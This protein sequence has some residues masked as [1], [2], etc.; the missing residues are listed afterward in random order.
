MEPGIREFFR[1]L[2]TSI[3]LLVLWMIVNMVI[4]IKYGYAFFENKIHISNII[5]YVW[6][7]ASFIAL[8]FLYI[9]IWKKPIEHLD[10]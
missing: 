5:F 2:V 9:K 6:V 4:G 1:R 3:S 8:I 7:A 10:D